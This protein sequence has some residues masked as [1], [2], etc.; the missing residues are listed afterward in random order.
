[1][2]ILEINVFYYRKGGSETVFFNTTEEL[3]RRGHEVIPFALKWDKNEESE[4]DKYF[5]E[6]KETR[7]GILRPLKNITTYFY[8]SE[9]AK[10]L[11]KLIEQEKPDI[12]QIHLIWGQFT[13]SI[14]KVLKKHNIPAVLTAHDYRLVCPSF[15]FLDGEGKVCER[16]EGRN[17]KNCFRNRCCKGSKVLSAMMASEQ[18]FRNKF[19]YPPKYLSGILYVSKFSEEKHLQYM[20]D[21]KKIPSLQLYN[22]STNIEGENKNLEKEKY[23]LYFGRLSREKGV[24]MLIK[25]FAQLKASSLK[26]V[27]TGPEEDAMKRIVKEKDITNIEFLGFKTGD[28]LKSLIQNAYFVIV[29]SEWYENNPMTIIES[30]SFGTPVIGAKIGGIPEIVVPGVTG[31]QFEV[32]NVND[33]CEKVRQAEELSEKEYQLFCQN[34]VQFAKTNFNKEKYFDKLEKFFEELKK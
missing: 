9:A 21:L 19:Y 32:G 17:F 34:A 12:A 16:C 8:H 14:L 1:M 27:G 31:F 26:I 20:P 25:S 18:Y 30:Y 10:K 23:F 7:G 2:K 24:E 5:P 3:K 29:P 11:E 33:L 4:Y 13:P 6:S 15:L 28:E 22:F